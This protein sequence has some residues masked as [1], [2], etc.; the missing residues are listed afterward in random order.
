MN[1]SSE[2]IPND[3]GFQP[4]LFDCC[5]D[6][7]FDILEDTD[8]PQIE[9]PHSEL[10]GFKTTLFGSEICQMQ[11][12]VRCI[13]VGIG[14]IGLDGRGLYWKSDMTYLFP[15]KDILDVSHKSIDL[16]VLVITLSKGKSIQL[17]ASMAHSIRS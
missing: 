14:T 2:T 4:G 12:F 5:D 15:W 16:E 9:S 6:D 10:S 1:F 3:F 11:L 8:V 13:D 7:G 17:S